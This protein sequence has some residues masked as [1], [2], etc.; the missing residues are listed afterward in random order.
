MKVGVKS[1]GNELQWVEAED[2][3]IEG[4]TLKDTFAQIKIEKIDTQNKIKALEDQITKLSGRQSRFANI[5][6][7]G[8]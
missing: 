2:I 1:Y 6:K 8:Q 4:V 3:V 7:R 5:F